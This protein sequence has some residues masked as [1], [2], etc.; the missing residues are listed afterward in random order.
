[1]LIYFSCEIENIKQLNCFELSRLLPI[2]LII[3]LKNPSGDSSFPVD[4]F[5]WRIAKCDGLKVLMF[6]VH[7]VDLR[8]LQL[9]TLLMATRRLIGLRCRTQ[10]YCEQ[11]CLLVFLYGTAWILNPYHCFVLYDLRSMTSSNLI[12]VL[13]AFGKAGILKHRRNRPFY[14]SLLNDLA[15]EW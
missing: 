4:R 2:G 12:I 1:M 9:W 10:R 11:F 7:S 15:F 5:L 8:S 14:S 6:L 13:W 3:E